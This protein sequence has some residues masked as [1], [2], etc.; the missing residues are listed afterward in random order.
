MRE[1]ASRVASPL[2]DGF[3]GPESGMRAIIIG[4]SADRAK[5]GNRAVRAYLKQ[6]WEVVAVNPNAAGT[7][8]EGVPVY[9]TVADVPKAEEGYDRALLYIPPRY[10]VNAVAQIAARVDVKEVWLNPGADGPEVIAEAERLGVRYVQAC[11]IMD[12]GPMVW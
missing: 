2:P 9:A 12:V 1:R 5:Y 7:E 3:G 4:A 8:V 10:G 6:G 11:A